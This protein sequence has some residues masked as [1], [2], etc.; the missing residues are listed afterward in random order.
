MPNSV[1]EE[2]MDIPMLD[3]QQGAKRQRMDT[4]ATTSQPQA[5]TVQSQTPATPLDQQMFSML[6]DVKQQICAIRQEHKGA[7]TDLESRFR[8]FE[9]AHAVHTVQHNGTP[10]ETNEVTISERST[11]ADEINR[12]N[13]IPAINI[14]A[15]SSRVSAMP[16]SVNLP[17]SSSSVSA[18]SMAAMSYKTIDLPEFAGFPEQWPIFIAAFRETTQ[19]F[20]YTPLQNI[21]HHLNNSIGHITA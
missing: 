17:A 14:P 9:L 16:V 20:N 18:M 11:P 8:A 6:L 21:F 10:S 13:N 5:G 3:A 2:N 1:D 4:T 12:T 19:T 7:I 15:S